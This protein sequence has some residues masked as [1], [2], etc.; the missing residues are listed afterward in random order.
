MSEAVSAL[1]C[2][3]TAETRPMAT[4][5]AAVVFIFMEISFCLNRLRRVGDRSLSTI[6]PYN[7]L[8]SGQ[9]IRTLDDW[10]TGRGIRMTGSGPRWRAAEPVK[11]ASREIAA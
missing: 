8:Q 6:T 5:Q 3:A 10:K 1:A 9:A 2:G 11:R 7:R 4:A